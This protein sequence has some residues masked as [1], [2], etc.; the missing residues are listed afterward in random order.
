MITKQE[1][2][3]MA[4]RV[5]EVRRQ[6]S[7][8]ISPQYGCMQSVVEA[9]QQVDDMT[10]ALKALEEA[11]AALDET[12]ELPTCLCINDYKDTHNNDCEW[13]HARAMLAKWR[14]E[15]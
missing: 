12:T 14:D 2:E 7:G 10:A 5:T 4:A 1:A 6:V 8:T 11:M 9:R 3:A 13:E 15:A